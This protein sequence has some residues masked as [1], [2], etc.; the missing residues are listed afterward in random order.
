M[1]SGIFRS[2]CAKPRWETTGI[3]LNLA[4]GNR[5]HNVKHD[6]SCFPNPFVQVTREVLGTLSQR[7]RTSSTKNVTKGKKE[8]HKKKPVTIDKKCENIKFTVTCIGGL[9]MTILTYKDS[10]S[11]SCP[12]SF[13]IS[14]FNALMPTVLFTNKSIINT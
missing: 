9:W 4:M 12:T 6:E 14:P 8:L 3:Y 11:V 5:E 13:G 1:S 10:N 2:F 7:A